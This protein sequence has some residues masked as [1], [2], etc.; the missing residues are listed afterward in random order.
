MKFYHEYLS[1]HTKFE[2][3]AFHFFGALCILAG[4]W[5]WPFVLVGLGTIAGS[6]YLFEGNSPGLLHVRCFSDLCEAV[7][8]IILMNLEFAWQNKVVLLIG[9]SIGISIEWFLRGPLSAL[10]GLC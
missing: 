10:L 9:I 7:A 1:H 8:G 5:Y 4:F 2:T 3:K 6:H